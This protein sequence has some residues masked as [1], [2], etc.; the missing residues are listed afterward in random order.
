MPEPHAEFA[1]PPFLC[2]LG[3]HQRYL[4]GAWFSSVRRCDRCDWTEDQHDA[5]KLDRER[6]LWAQGPPGEKV[7][8]GLARVALA[9]AKDTIHSDRDANA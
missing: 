1:K 9:M 7:E 2:R 4:D 3:F 8:E 5:E 6:Q